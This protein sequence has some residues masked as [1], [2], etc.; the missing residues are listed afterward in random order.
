MIFHNLRKREHIDVEQKRPKNG[1]QRH[2]ELSRY[3]KDSTYSIYMA[4]NLQIA[5]KRALKDPEQINQTDYLIVT[6]FMICL[7]QII[8]H[9][10]G[11]QRI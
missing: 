11:E 3:T 9:T 5:L 2:T 8:K 6:F 7:A 10:G 4:S 1:H